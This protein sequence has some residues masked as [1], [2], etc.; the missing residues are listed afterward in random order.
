M[1]VSKH[2]LQGGGPSTLPLC[3]GAPGSPV[4]LGLLSPGTHAGGKSIPA[5]PSAGLS[6]GQSWFPMTFV[7]HS[8]LAFGFWEFLGKLR[9]ETKRPWL[10]LQLWSGQAALGA[11]NLSS[12]VSSH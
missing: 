12:L 11:G 6:L 2:A 1:E 4:T 8:W 7:Q 3:L 9:R 10:L 5:A